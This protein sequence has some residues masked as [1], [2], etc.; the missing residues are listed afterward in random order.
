MVKLNTTI[1]AEKK[2]LSVLPAQT[3]TPGPENILRI[4]AIA[5]TK[6]NVPMYTLVTKTMKNKTF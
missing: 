2:F 5:D 3:D 6:I 4:M 1:F